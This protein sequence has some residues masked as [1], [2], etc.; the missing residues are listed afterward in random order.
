[1]RWGPIVPGYNDGPYEIDWTYLFDAYVLERK[2]STEA[3]EFFNAFFKSW[4]VQRTT[5]SLGIWYEREEW[6]KS[7]KRVVLIQAKGL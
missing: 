7:Y 3:P 5:T 6:V 2:C 1:M 4:P